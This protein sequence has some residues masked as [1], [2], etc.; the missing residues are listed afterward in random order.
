VLVHPARLVVNIEAV[1]QTPPTTMAGLAFVLAYS[2]ENSQIAE[3]FDCDL[4]Y[5]QTFISTLATAAG[6]LARVS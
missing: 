5:G 6:R 4:E 3:L 2:R 1:L